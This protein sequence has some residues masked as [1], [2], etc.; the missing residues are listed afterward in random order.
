MNL[1]YLSGLTAKYVLILAINLAWRI[2]P[3]NW[4]LILQAGAYILEGSVSL[5]RLPRFINKFEEILVCT[6]E[7]FDIWN[8]KEIQSTDHPWVHCFTQRTIAEPLENFSTLVYSVF[9]F[10]QLEK[11]VRQYISVMWNN[12]YFYSFLM[13]I[14]NW[15][16]YDF[17]GLVTSITDVLPP[18][19]RD[20]QQRPHIYITDGRVVFFYLCYY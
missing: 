17:L 8:D 6:T 3:L 1:F 13:H 9:P 12:V 10:L 15:L 19:N 14:N 11:H 2:I 20:R 16:S 18:S 7:S 5:N 4:C